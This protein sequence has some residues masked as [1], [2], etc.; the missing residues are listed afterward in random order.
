[1][2]VNKDTFGTNY[3]FQN[4]VSLTV[5]NCIIIALS[6]KFSYVRNFTDTVTIQ[7][8]EYYKGYIRCKDTE[9]LK[10]YWNIP[11]VL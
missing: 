10:K 1:M 7:G 2:K 8:Q 3:E 6:E 11:M 5:L 4:P 9:Q